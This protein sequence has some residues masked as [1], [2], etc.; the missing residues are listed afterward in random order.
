MQDALRHFP[1]RPLTPDERSLLAE[2]LAHAGDITSAYVSS[3]QSDDPALYRRI[4]IISKLDQ[5]PSHLIH[6]PPGRLI[7]LVFSFERRP[8][9]KRFRTLRE[10][11]NSVR[12]VLPDTAA[13]TDRG[14]CL[15]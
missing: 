5:G 6:A 11:L 1:A 12:P 3:R 13:D 9:I 14:N 15:G 2:W 8:R 7:W 4:V 10:A